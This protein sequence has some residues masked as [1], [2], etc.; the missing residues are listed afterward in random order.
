MD[1]EAVKDLRVA[2]V[3]FT[4][5]D[6]DCLVSESFLLLP[7]MALSDITDLDFVVMHYGHTPY[8]VAKIEEVAYLK[9]AGN[10]VQIRC[11]EVRNVWDSEA[12][13][14]ELKKVYR[15]FDGSR[16]SVVACSSNQFFALG[17][18]VQMKVKA[19]GLGGL[20]LKRAIAEIADTYGVLSSQVEISITAVERDYLSQT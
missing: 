18:T 9:S 15:N 11:S 1:L 16:P 3:S 7:R 12:A 8:W 4:Q 6:F 2:F 10:T 5:D 19:P 13:K 14:A 20:S 17:T